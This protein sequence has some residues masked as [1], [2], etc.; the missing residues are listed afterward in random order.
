MTTVFLR[1]KNPSTISRS[2]ALACSAENRTGVGGSSVSKV[3]R[4]R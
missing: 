4:G 3:A 1:K 2:R